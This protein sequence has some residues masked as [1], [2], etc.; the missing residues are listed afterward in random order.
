M[1]SQLRLLQEAN[2]V[3]LPSMARAREIY[4]AAKT[5]FPIVYENFSFEGWMHFLINTTMMIQIQ[6]LGLDEQVV[7]ITALGR[8]FLHYLVG[9]NLSFDKAG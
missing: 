1:G 9:D 8:D 5:A 7:R 6:P 3:P 2:A 4:E